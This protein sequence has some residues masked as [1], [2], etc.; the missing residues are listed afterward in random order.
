[1]LTT[2]Q[3]LD[4]AKT[5]AG[6]TS[7]YRLARTIPV[8]DNTL[9]NWRHGI[10]SPDEERSARLA[11]MAGLDV[12]YV[13][14]CMAAARAKDEGLKSAW[15]MLAKRLE[16]I[17]AA[18]LLAIL[19]NLGAVSFDRGA[20]A[21]NGITAP[22]VAKMANLTAYISWQVC[23]AASCGCSRCFGCCQALPM[24]LPPATG[25]QGRKASAHGRISPGPTQPS[26][27]QAHTAPPGTPARTRTSPSDPASAT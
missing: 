5:A 21:S 2:D 7:D 17:A 26:P 14:T 24:A 8:S 10:T 16:G 4:A 9:Y 22:S 23:Y 18:L 12:G 13:L 27:T 6:I 25:G 1:M 15:S 20:L 3:L 11:E 19:T